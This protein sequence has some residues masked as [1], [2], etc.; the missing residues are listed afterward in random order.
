MTMSYEEAVDEL[1]AIVRRIEDGNV[2][3][4]ESIRLY[5]KGSQLV[6]RCEKLLEEAELKITLLD[7]ESSP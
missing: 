4:E 3:L 2:S 5:E 7:R 6:K 1:R